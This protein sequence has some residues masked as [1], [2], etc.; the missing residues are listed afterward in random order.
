MNEE[1]L[2]ILKL[3]EEGKI[4]SAEAV[5]LLEALDRTTAKPTEA[6]LK[7]KWLHVKVEKDGRDTVNIRVPL[8]L[9]RFGFKIAPHA[10]AHSARQAER[11]AERMR[12]HGERMRRMADKLQ[13]RIDRSLGDKV[14]KDF[15]IDIGSIIDEAVEEAASENGGHGALRGILGE[16]LDLDLDKIL[17]MAQSKDFDWKVL[18]VYD[19]EEDKHVVVRLE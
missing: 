16:D 4:N 5:R 7:R 17:E 13:E 12:R 8:A 2:R 11:H 18:D 14:G 1:K 15:K 10:M 19:D 9:L 6:D 3:L